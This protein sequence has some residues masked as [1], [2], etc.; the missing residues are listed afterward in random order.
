MLTVYSFD[1]TA[2]ESCETAIMNALVLDSTNA[3]AL[4]TLASIRISQC[5]K[6]EA[7][8]ILEG[9]HRR[10]DAAIRQYTARTLQD[11]LRCTDED[12]EHINNLPTPEHC[13]ALVKLLLE[14]APERRSFASYSEG[15][16]KFVL[17]F[18]DEN[19]EVWYLLGM[20]NKSMETPDV[21]A[22]IESFAQ[23]RVLLEPLLKQL[24]LQRQHQPAAPALG[25]AEECEQTSIETLLCAVEAAE[26][27]LVAT[28]GEA[29]VQAAS[30]AATEAMQANEADDSAMEEVVAAAVAAT[31]AQP[32]A[33]FQ[34][35]A[36]AFAAR[37]PQLWGPE[38]E[39]E[40]S[41]DDE[42]NA[43]DAS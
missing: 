18:D 4:Q 6:P 11:D 23:C 22:A 5:R 26:A 16:L 33:A 42:E 21:E 14:C 40:W 31:G 39:D 9:L 20:S 10:Y 38:E 43:M 41:T 28:H 24:R 1:P 12:L 35:T 17:Q 32:A 2:E 19:P 37:G 25:G 30:T 36:A 29:R 27:D 8:D 3:E 7:C 15:L 34:F 13:V